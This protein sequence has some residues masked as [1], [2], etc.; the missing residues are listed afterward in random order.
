[1]TIPTRIDAVMAARRRV[2]PGPR[3][4]PLVG[5]MFDFLC[6]NL[7]FVT[8]MAQRYGDVV[9]YRKGACPGTKST[10]R[11]HPAHVAGKQPQLL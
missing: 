7:A 5:S 10:P 1:M 11:R 9:Q 2:P 6:D 8:D 3:G 4:R